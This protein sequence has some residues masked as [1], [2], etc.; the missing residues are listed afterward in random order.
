MQGIRREMWVLR[1]RVT[2]LGNVLPQKT[3][4]NPPDENSSLLRNIR[5]T[6]VKDGAEYY[7]ACCDS[8]SIEGEISKVLVRDG[9]G[10]IGVD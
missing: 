1:W 9:L 8:H 3:F 5:M 4:S 2:G 7:S 10:G 6:E